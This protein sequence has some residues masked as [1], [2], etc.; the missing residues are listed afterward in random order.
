MS[1]QRR[2]EL[3]LDR[4]FIYDLTKDSWSRGQQLPPNDESTGNFQ[5]ESGKSIRLD[6]LQALRGW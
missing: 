4:Q 2:R 6:N 5:D 1:R 3:E